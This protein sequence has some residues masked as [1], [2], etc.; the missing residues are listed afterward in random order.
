MFLPLTAFDRGFE[1]EEQKAM[2]RRT[3]AVAIKTIGIDTGKNTMHM[4]GLDKKGAIVLREKVSRHRV[5]A[6]LV[7]VPRCLVGIEAG[8]VTWPASWLRS[9]TKSNRYRPPLRRRFGKAPT[10]G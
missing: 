10:P 8:M 7:N 2:S 9:V 1:H 6:R 3:S 4:I 5:A